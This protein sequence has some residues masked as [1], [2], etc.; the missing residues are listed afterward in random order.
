MKRKTW[1]LLWFNQIKKEKLRT[2]KIHQTQSDQKENLDFAMKLLRYRAFSF[3]KFTT[4]SD[5]E[6]IEKE[7][8]AFEIV[9]ESLTLSSRTSEISDRSWSLN[10][11]SL[12]NSIFSPKLSIDVA[13]I[14]YGE[15]SMDSLILG[16]GLLRFEFRYWFSLLLRIL[17]AILAI[18]DFCLS[19]P[20]NEEQG[21]NSVNG[22]FV[23]IFDSVSCG[24]RVAPW[25]WTYLIEWAQS[26][27]LWSY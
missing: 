20:P 8:K 26:K 4:T 19:F 2:K 24:S 10:L 12:S 21:R 27:L 23:I 9:I 13:L 6:T 3:L 7:R 1:I 5:E 22:N 16:F 15:S 11:E 25:Y 18:S 17:W 14:H